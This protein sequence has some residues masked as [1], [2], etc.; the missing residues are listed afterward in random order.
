M[1]TRAARRQAPGR[2]A[3]APWLGAGVL[4]A[5]VGCASEPT[6]LSF[7]E[8]GGAA[9]AGPVEPDG[10]PQKGPFDITIASSPPIDVT[11]AV[12]WLDPNFGI[13]HAGAEARTWTD[14]SGF[15]LV[16]ERP[17]VDQAGPTLDRLGGQG[18]LRFGGG[19]RLVLSHAVDETA[20]A[21]LTLGGDGFLLAMV[22]QADADRAATVFTLTPED[23]AAGGARLQ[24]TP[25]R[26]TLDQAGQQTI[27]E[28]PGALQPGVPHLVIVSSL[29]GML[30]LRIDGQ[31][32]ATHDV[33]AASL[34]FESPAVGGAG[35]PALGL[36]G[37]L[38]D[39]VLVA[40]PG[41]ASATDP[42]ELYLGK[43]YGL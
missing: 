5:L 34:P 4:L 35:A 8:D 2:L 26:F 19:A 28:A 30:S 36:E 16:L 1:R 33:P 29:G 23:P 25:V 42:L 22:V 18:A 6:T 11:G 41:V 40:G 39:V 37:L 3:R 7:S 38:G 17:P 9:D 31:T 15:G 43:K 20:R 32:V 10:E 27:I 14:R 13:A 12:L 21:A 24:L